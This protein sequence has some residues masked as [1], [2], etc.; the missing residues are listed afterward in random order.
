MELL[1]V[2][3]NDI[4]QLVDLLQLLLN[5]RRILCNILGMLSFLSDL[6]VHLLGDIQ[7]RMDRI[8]NNGAGASRR[9]KA[10]QQY[11]QSTSL[12]IFMLTPQSG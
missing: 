10:P 3:V 2:L 5:H 6:P 12:F 4:C 8:M 11:Y 7:N 9:A 1:D